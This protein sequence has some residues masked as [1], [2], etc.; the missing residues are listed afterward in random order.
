MSV[1]SALAGLVNKEIVV[2]AGCAMLV[3]AIVAILSVELNAVV[4][5]R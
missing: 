1:S 5:H 3:V 2:V 4:A